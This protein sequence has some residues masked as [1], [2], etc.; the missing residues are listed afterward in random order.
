[1]AEEN[2]R[3]HTV[4]KDI[5][6]NDSKVL[7]GDSPPPQPVAATVA[8]TTAAATTTTTTTTITSTTQANSVMSSCLQTHNLG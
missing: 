3:S 8:A 1:M 7:I 2:A 4:V 5:S 6:E